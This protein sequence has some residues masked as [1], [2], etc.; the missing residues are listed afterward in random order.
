M[1][2]HQNLMAR[3]WCY[4]SLVPPEVAVAYR[5]QTRLPQ[6]LHPLWIEFLVDLADNRLDEDEIQCR[7]L[8]LFHGIDRAGEVISDLQAA[9]LAPR[10]SVMRELMEKDIRALH[11]HAQ[12]SAI[13]PVERPGGRGRECTSMEGHP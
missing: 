10:M 13:V 12:G 6:H 7:Y 4:V 3:L 11:L 8:P 5:V 1:N 9:W 2:E